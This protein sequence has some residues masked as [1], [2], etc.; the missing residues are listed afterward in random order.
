MATKVVPWNVGNGNITLSYNG[1]GDGT[2]SVSSDI[3]NL[4]AVRSQQVTVQAGNVTKV[5]NIVQRGN[6]NYNETWHPVSYESDHAYYSASSIENGYT[7]SDSTTYAQIN[8]TRGSNAVTYIYY[9]FNTSDIPD[10]ATINSVSCKIKVSISNTQSNRVSTRQA[11]LYSNTTAKGS[12]YTIT[13]TASETTMS[14]G[15]WTAAELKNNLRLRLYAVRGTNSTNSN[16]YIN[17]YGATLSV[18]Y[19]YQGK[20]FNLDFN[21][22]FLRR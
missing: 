8:L 9:K 1:E 11:R 5:V 16:Y 17:F 4:N 18:S 7:D 15:S 14:V 20:D 12:D 3:N 22:D 19:T 13:G 6:P 2:I 10:G 21:G